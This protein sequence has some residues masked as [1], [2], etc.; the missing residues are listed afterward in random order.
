MAVQNVFF[1]SRTRE[2]EGFEHWSLAQYSESS[3]VKRVVV[4]NIARMVG[5]I[6]KISTFF[7]TRNLIY[8]FH[9]KYPSSRN[10]SSTCH[11]K[12]LRELNEGVGNMGPEITV[13]LFSIYALS[14][15]QRVTYFL[16]SSVY[17]AMDQEI[18][19]KNW[20]AS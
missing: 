15:I 7:L 2:T 19:I 1:P 8:L 5:Y 20:L 4:D 3:T 16:R 11:P 18:L 13:N 10:S 6:L 12:K 17:L 14:F 9:V